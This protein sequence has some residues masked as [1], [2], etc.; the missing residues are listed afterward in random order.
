MPNENDVLCSACSSLQYTGSIAKIY[1][2]L[3]NYLSLTYTIPVRIF[4][5]SVVWI[6]NSQLTTA[7]TTLL[8]LVVSLC[9]ESETSVDRGGV[10]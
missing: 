2:D 4:D 5:Q 10:I 9:P 6:A 7:F 8:T 1:D 3:S